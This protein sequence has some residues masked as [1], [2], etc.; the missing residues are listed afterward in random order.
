MMG[1]IADTLGYLGDYRKCDGVAVNLYPANRSAGLSHSER[2]ILSEIHRR[3]G[4]AILIGEW[5][6][7]ALDSGLYAN[8]AKLDWSYPETVET[9]ADRARQAACVTADLHGLP[10]VVGAHWFTWRDADSPKR[11]AN[12]GLFRFNGEPWRELLDALAAVHGRLAGVPP[13]P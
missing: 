13:P 5:S 10:F 12:R 7:P 11:Q 6:V 2:A 8:P 4:K 9:Q 1:G 3:T